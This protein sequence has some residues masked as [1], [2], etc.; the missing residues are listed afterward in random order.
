MSFFGDNADETELA[1]TTVFKLVNH[2]GR[3]IGIAARGH[4]GVLT[5]HMQKTGT[6]HDIVNVGPSMGVVGGYT[7]P[8]LIQACA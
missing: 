7:H 3:N 8:G 4:R 6:F 5:V 2:A 1:G